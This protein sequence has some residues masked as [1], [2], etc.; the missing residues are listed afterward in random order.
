MSRAV[1]SMPHGFPRAVGQAPDLEEFGATLVGEGEKSLW[2]QR[3]YNH[4]RHDS[5]Q[6]LAAH[7]QQSSTKSENHVVF[8]FFCFFFF[9]FFKKKKKKKKKISGTF[10]IAGAEAMPPASGESDERWHV[11]V[12]GSTLIIALISDLPNPTRH[13]RAELC[14]K[15][16]QTPPAQHMSPLV[17]VRC[18][19]SISPVAGPVRR[20][21]FISESPGYWKKRWPR[22]TRS[23]LAWSIARRTRPCCGIQRRQLVA[24]RGG[25]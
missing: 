17:A 16:S 14:R 13:S 25:G 23:A 7:T 24:R 18:R 12:R 9:F 19:P 15:A 8:C 10:S 20:K 1:R 11:D 3:A 2:P 4:A 22:A 5:P 21:T 6:F